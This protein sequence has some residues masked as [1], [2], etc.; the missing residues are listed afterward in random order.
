MEDVSSDVY[1]YYKFDVTNMDRFVDEIVK[2]R[3]IQ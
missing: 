1:T 3:V 2:Q